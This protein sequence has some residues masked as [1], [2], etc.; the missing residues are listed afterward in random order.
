M[1]YSDSNILNLT[2]DAVHHITSQARLVKCEVTSTHDSESKTIY[3]DRWTEYH[4]DHADLESLNA[5]AGH[6]ATITRCH[7]CD[8][9]SLT[10]ETL[11]YITVAVPSSLRM[12]C[13]TWSNR[14]SKSSSINQE[15]VPVIS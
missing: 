7:V 1:E 5:L 6:M 15:H 11:R 2:Y 3:T 4:R 14:S 13:R 9:C 8:Y 12:T 10:F